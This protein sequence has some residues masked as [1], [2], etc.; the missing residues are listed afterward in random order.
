MVRMVQELL[1]NERV[2]H[3]TYKGTNSKS[4]KIPCGVPQGSVLGPILFKL[5]ANDIPN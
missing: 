1:V 4:L 5:Y 3:V 2:Q